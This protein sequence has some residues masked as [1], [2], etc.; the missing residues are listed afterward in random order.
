MQLE[1]N[2]VEELII[3]LLSLQT[4]IVFTI[5]NLVSPAWQEKKKI[6]INVM[7]GLQDPKSESSFGLEGHWMFLGQA[8]IFIIPNL[9]RTGKEWETLQQINIINVSISPT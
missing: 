5:Q 4:I 1:Q 9:I 2:L 3:R 7:L 8:L 6:V